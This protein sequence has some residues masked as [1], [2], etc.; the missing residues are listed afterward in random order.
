MPP[1]R[2]ARRSWQTIPCS[3]SERW[4]DVPAGRRRRHAGRLV[5]DHWQRLA[6]ERRIEVFDLDL[7]GA[8]NILPCWNLAT[9]PTSRLLGPR[10]IV[11]H[12]LESNAALF[13]PPCRDPTPRMLACTSWRGDY[14]PRLAL[15]VPPADVD[16][17]AHEDAVLAHCLPTV[18]QLVRC[19][20]ASMSRSAYA[21]TACSTTSRLGRA[22][23]LNERAG[24]VIDELKR[25]CATWA[26][27]QSRSVTAFSV[28]RRFPALDQQI[29]RH[30][31]HGHAP[32]GQR[33]RAQCA[34][35][36]ARSDTRHVGTRDDAPTPASTVRS[37]MLRVLI[38]DPPRC[39]ARDKCACV[40]VSRTQG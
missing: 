13:V 14:L 32:A 39:A 4:F 21:R 16:S 19:I 1:H 29:Q 17:L 5:F 8:P 35:A 18:A 22:V 7:W 24:A 34:P 10:R 36:G 37:T 30:G 31:A 33:P 12:V 26:G 27:T 28:K 11:Q 40:R 3:V 15:K 25:T 6:P 9:L 23:L 38:A 20:N 2:L